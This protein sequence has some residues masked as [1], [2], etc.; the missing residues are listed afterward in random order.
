MTG[1]HV[2]EAARGGIVL[3]IKERGVAVF[4]GRVV[5]HL[6]DASD[7]SRDIVA[8]A[9]GVR[10]QGS[11]EAGH[12]E[13]GGDAFAGDVAKGHAQLAVG[14]SEKVVVVAANTKSGA[15]CA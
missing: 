1:I 15:A 13:S 4:G 12:G 5:E 8:G 14:K 9:H 10:A 7:E 3:R 6:V 11:L 2:A